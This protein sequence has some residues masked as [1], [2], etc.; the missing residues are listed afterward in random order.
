[1]RGAIAGVDRTVPISDMTTLREQVASTF[2]SQRLAARFVSAFG[3]LAVLLACVGLYGT[4]AQ[5][6]ARRTSEIGLRLALGAQRLDVLRMIL[7]DTLVVVIAGLVA[8]IPAAFGAGRF[9]AS[10][11][12]GLSPR[13]PL[14][15]AFAAG[16]MT[17]VAAIAGLLPAR[18]ATKVDPLVAL[19]CE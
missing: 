8:G 19:R 10:Q 1:V 16:L 14:S 11:L 18:R 6:V 7:L 12:Y 13:D 17:V 4:V 9:V 3:G 2:N 15:L 5:T